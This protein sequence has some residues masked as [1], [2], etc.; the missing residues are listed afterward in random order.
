MG[1]EGRRGCAGR[2]GIVGIGGLARRLAPQCFLHRE[3][4]LIHLGLDVWSDLVWQQID[5]PEQARP[6]FTVGEHLNRGAVLL[7][8]FADHS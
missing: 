3:R 1:P 8:P 5:G 6:R 2:S 4:P 7:H